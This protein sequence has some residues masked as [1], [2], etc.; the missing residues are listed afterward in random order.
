VRWGRRHLLGSALGPAGSRG[1][2]TRLFKRPHGGTRSA[3]SAPL[4]AGLLV[5]IV[6]ASPVALP[7]SLGGAQSGP[8][9]ID[10]LST[11]ETT[12]TRAIANVRA[13][14][15]PRGEVVAVLPARASPEVLGRT[16][17][18]AWLMVAVPGSAADAVRGWLPADR[19]DLPPDR[20][21][22]L[23]VLALPE[24]AP[25][26]E[27]SA[28][29]ALP[30]LTL[31]AVFLMK[32][33]RIALDIRNEGEGSLLDKKIPLLVT[34]ASGETV[35]VLEVGPATLAARGV[36]TVVTPIVVTSTGTYTLEL[37]RQE[38]IPEAARTNNSVTRLLVV[39]GG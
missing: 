7:E 30:D 26:A 1:P 24:S 31:G 14:P 6:F 38:S 27:A 20:R 29:T 21:D 3:H 18:G 9:V 4:L 34:R 10:P 35:G 12:E 22:A 17:D 13:R 36:A 37:D 25:A 19:L 23:E 32:D 39:G 33:G 16:A 28:P 2:T 8:A 11:I 15:D 5:L